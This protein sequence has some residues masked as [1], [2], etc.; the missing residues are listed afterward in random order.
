[1]VRGQAQLLLRLVEVGLQDPVD[2]VDGQLL[3]GPVVDGV[4]DVEAQAAQRGARALRGQ[5]LL[6]LALLPM[7]MGPASVYRH[8]LRC[9]NTNRCNRTVAKQLQPHTAAAAK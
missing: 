5:A 4:V 2:P 6:R 8:E 1:M 9:S 3:V 7:S